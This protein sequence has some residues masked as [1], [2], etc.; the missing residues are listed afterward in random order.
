[1]K[2]TINTDTGRKRPGVSEE[3]PRKRPNETSNEFGL[4]H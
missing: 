1:M 2:A 4:K 3:Y